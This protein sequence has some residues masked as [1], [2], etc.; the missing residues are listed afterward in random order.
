MEK[1]EVGM[2]E[3]IEEISRRERVKMAGLRK[4]TLL[5]VG[6]LDLVERTMAAQ[7]GAKAESS[8]VGLELEPLER[9]VGGVPLLPRRRFG[10]DASAKSLFGV[11]LDILEELG[12]PMAAAAGVVR[13][14]GEALMRR[15]FDAF[16]QDDAAVFTA[17][18]E[19]T[20]EAPRT[21]S[22]LAQ[23]SL[24]AHVASLAREIAG[25]LPEGRTW[26]TVCPVCGSLPLIS[27][28]VG[29]EGGRVHTCSFCRASYRTVRLQCP[30]CQ[31]QDAGKL[32]FFTADE[33]PGFRVDACLTCQGYIKTVDFREFDRVSVPVLDDLESMMLDMMAA[34]RGFK[35]HTLCAW[36][37]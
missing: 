37:F 19:Q 6:L 26:G 31:E 17:F 11:L 25:R 1:N 30:Y 14:G 18:G 36:G 4:K 12:G 28:L 33:E 13:E 5:P 3:S 9:V 10:S 22:Y 29:K 15:G 34:K 35:R 8:A 24:T 27:A 16:L 2:F 32:P 21:L 7:A 20:P 23:S